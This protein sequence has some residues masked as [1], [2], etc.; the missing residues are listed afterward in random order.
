M[1][2]VNADKIIIGNTTLSEDGA[3]GLVN[4]DSTQGSIEQRLT[5]L[6][7]AAAAPT[8]KTAT[9]TINNSTFISS[10]KGFQQGK[11]IILLVNLTGTPVVKTGGSAVTV[12]SLTGIDLSV[13]GPALNNVI[14]ARTT[15]A[16]A[17]YHMA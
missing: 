4:Y 14:V 2:T 9:V 10:I 6:E 17:N 1:I 11:I 5:D 15:P 3:L 8:F 13:L 16:A 7:S 12:G